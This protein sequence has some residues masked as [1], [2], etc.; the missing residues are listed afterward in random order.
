VLELSYTL[1][2]SPSQTTSPL[3]IENGLLSLVHERRITLP[4]GT[5]ITYVQIF[6]SLVEIMLPVKLVKMPPHA[7]LNINETFHY[8]VSKIILLVSTDK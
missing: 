8:I 6:P 7:K 5:W 1:T 2:E 4:L 3:L